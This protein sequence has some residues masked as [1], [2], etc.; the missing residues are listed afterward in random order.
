MSKLLRR[1]GRHFDTS[2]NNYGSISECAVPLY[3]HHRGRNKANDGIDDQ[4]SVPRFKEL[5]DKTPFRNKN[6]LGR[7][8]RILFR[9]DH[10][11]KADG[12]CRVYIAHLSYLA[13]LDMVDEP[14]AGLLPL[15]EDPPARDAIR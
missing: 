13:G 2:M 12:L 7:L 6:K 9:E 14:D 5:S 1:F 8:G 3:M 4:A 15:L 10:P 11:R